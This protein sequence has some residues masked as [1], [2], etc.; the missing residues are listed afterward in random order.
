[1]K[2]GKPMLCCVFFQT[3]HMFVYKNH[4]L[5]HTYAYFLINIFQEI[6]ELGKKGQL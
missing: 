2:V 5:L 1:M 6:N 3:Q 4:L